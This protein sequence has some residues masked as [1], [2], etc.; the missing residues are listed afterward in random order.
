MWGS[1]PAP[2]V[3]TTIPDPLHPFYPLG[4]EIANYVANDQNALELLA[5]FLSGWVVILGVTWWAVGKYS[6]QVGKLDK[7]IMLWFVLTGTIHTF[8]EGYFAYNGGHMAGAQ[9]LFGQLWKEY[10]KSDSRYLTWDPFTLCMETVTAVCWG[11]LSYVTA[12]LITVQHPYRFPIQA[13]VSTG[14]IYGLILY[15]A[16]CLFDLYHENISYCRPGAY[17]FW[18]Y[19]FFVNFIWM[20]I[21]GYLLYQSVART[22]DA[23]RALD[24][25][26]KSLAG[27][28]AVKA[29]AKKPHANGSAKTPKKNA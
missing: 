8:F 14:Q 26:S 13:L 23:F 7:T 16:T 4:V 1:K 25:M 15:Y 6:P 24:R 11:P 12:Y 29:S 10:A 27:N 5:K 28:G 19:F 9:D 22:G 20:V 18:F 21:P 17:Y 3:E 2:V